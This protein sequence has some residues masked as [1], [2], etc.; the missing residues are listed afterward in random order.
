MTS[1]TYYAIVT[2]GAASRGE[3]RSYYRS[4]ESAKRD[5]ASLSGGSMT[6]ARVVECASRSEAMGASISDGY[7]VVASR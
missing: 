3:H 5:L 7:P 6:S 4:I 1:Q 2:F